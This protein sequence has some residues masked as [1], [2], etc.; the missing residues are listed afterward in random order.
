MTPQEEIKVLQSLSQRA[1]AFLLGVTPRTIRAYTDLR[2]NDDGTYDCRAVVEWVKV[3][4]RP[5][6][7]PFGDRELIALLVGG[8]SITDGILTE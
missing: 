3:K 6:V 8:G 1:V 5:A 2:R 7:A 4:A